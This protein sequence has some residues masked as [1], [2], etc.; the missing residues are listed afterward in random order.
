LKPSDQKI[1][2]TA[3]AG[4]AASVHDQHETGR[5]FIEG[6]LM[7]SAGRFGGRLRLDIFA[8]RHEAQRECF[9]HHARLIGG[10][11]HYAVRR[12]AANAPAK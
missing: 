12:D 6:A 10:H 8:H 4:L 5:T 9:A 3:A 1:A 2:A 7:H 11:R